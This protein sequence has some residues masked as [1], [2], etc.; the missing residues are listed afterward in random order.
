MESMRKN[1]QINNDNL[2]E[3]IYSLNEMLKL[4][5]FRY[6]NEFFLLYLKF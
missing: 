4:N 1:N 6:K 3:Y 2:Q 5:Y